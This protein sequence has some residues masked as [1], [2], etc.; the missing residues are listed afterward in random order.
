VVVKATIKGTPYK[1][2]SVEENHKN[3]ISQQDV[4][5]FLAQAEALGRNLGSP[6]TARPR[7]KVLE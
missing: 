4:G 2:N 6:R 3:Y 5:F 7:Q 1:A